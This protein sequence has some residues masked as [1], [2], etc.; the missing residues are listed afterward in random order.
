MAL[1]NLEERNALGCSRAKYCDERP[2]RMR[3]ATLFGRAAVLEFHPDLQ[4]SVPLL[5]PLLAATVP[6][7]QWLAP[8]QLPLLVKLFDVTLERQRALRQVILLYV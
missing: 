5:H 2:G 8:C 3:C 4:Y 6:N 7:P 1:S